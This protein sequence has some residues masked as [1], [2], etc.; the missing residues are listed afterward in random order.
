MI[1]TL[2]LQPELLLLDEPFSALDYQTRLSVCEDIYRI[3]KKEQKTAV[4]VT[5]DLS[6]AISMAD[7]IFV[8][9]KR[10]AGIKKEIKLDFNMK[11]RPPM[12][13]RN[14]PQFRDYFNL[15]WKEL[16]EHD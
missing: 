10:P 13:V 16:N 8:L 7:R 12:Q 15:I 14:A 1:R 6:E 3:I 4:L 11:E 5:H 2:A 9:S